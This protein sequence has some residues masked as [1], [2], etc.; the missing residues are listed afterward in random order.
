MKNLKSTY[1]FV[2]RF[3]LYLIK[4]GWL[5]PTIS[6]IEEVSVASLRELHDKEIVHI[7]QH[8][9][10]EKNLNDRCPG[11]PRLTSSLSNTLVTE[12]PLS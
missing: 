10:D 4:N 8:Y 2:T 11:K 5:N 6:I 3:D 9:D 7:L 1:T 12:H